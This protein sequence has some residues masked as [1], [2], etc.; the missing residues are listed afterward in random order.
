MQFNYQ[1][2]WLEKLKTIE[3]QQEQHRLAA[4]KAKGL[5]QVD[6]RASKLR[7][8]ALL[9]KIKEQDKNQTHWED[10]LNWKIPKY[11]NVK[12]TEALM[13]QIS[14]N[15]DFKSQSSGS[16]PWLS[17]K[18]ALLKESVP[19]NEYQTHA[20]TGGV[21]RDDLGGHNQKAG[22]GKEYI[23]ELQRASEIVKAQ[24]NM[25]ERSVDVGKLQGYGGGSRE[26]AHLLDRNMLKELEQGNQRAMREV[27][28]DKESMLNEYYYNKKALGRIGTAQSGN[29]RVSA[30]H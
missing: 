16:K 14:S 28:R 7:N 13:N 12:P 18:M 1:K 27:K 20:Y 4:Q 11:K 30:L 26:E 15:A 2:D 23:K 21:V 22:G 17:K 9:N 8:E 24:N 29:Q 3:K 19:S 6:T 25:L 5:K 10:K